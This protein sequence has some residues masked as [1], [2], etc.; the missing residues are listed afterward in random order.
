MQIFPRNY[1]F[2]NNPAGQNLL[3][4]LQNEE[5]SLALNEAFVFCEF[6]L[7]REDE[8]VLLSQ[9]LIISKHHGVI[10]FGAFSGSYADDLASLETHVHQTEAVFSHV[11]SK[12]IKNAKLRQS[13]TSLKFSAE[14]FV[15]ASEAPEM[16]AR[17]ET[18]VLRSL[19]A[20]SDVLNGLHT[21]PPIDSETLSEITSVVEGSK[22][23][24]RPKDRK[25]TQFHVGSKVALVKSLEDEIRRFDR[26]QRLCFMTEVF[27]PQRITGL[28]GSGKTVVIAMQAALAHLKNPE[29]DIAVTFYTK[30][31]YQRRFQVPSATLG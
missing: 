4:H 12:L 9:I 10:I 16:E 21:E 24:L 14:A 31:L 6:P 19:V 15:F 23:L 30:S 11:Y 20:V 22:G 13:R 25:T 7:F 1:R 18:K 17:E 26:E 28:A 29:V 3:E 8:D 27:G 5:I 2:A